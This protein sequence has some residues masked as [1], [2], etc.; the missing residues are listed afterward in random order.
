MPLMLVI[1]YEQII[2]I[3]MLMPLKKDRAILINSVWGG[4]CAL[5][6]NFLLV[7]K[8]ESVGSAFVWVISE[9]I[10]LFS[11]QYFISKYAKFEFPLSKFVG[12]IVSSLPIIIVFLLLKKR[13]DNNSILQP[14]I[15][16]IV[17][18][19]YYYVLEVK[20]FK[21]EIVISNSMKFARLC[22]S[23]FQ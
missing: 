2:I 16:S 13:I 15:I 22:K 23:V 12:R 5:L 11:A 18:S 21:N 20:L 7:P 6:L 8:F 17:I 10:V 4:G 14:I 1:G 9:L 3:Q 19:L